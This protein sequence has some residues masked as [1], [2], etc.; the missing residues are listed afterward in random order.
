MEQIRKHNN[1]RPQE[2]SE[3]AKQRLVQ[4]IVRNLLDIQI[5]RL[6]R[7]EPTWGYRL[8]KQAEAKFGIK[9]RHGALYPSLN[10]LEQEGFLTSHGQKQRGRTR[11]VYTITEKGKR[12]VDTYHKILKDQI[13]G[14]DLK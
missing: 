8:K 4:R 3:T 12:Y 14:E 5:L 9:L 13:E 2:L 10:A 1:P 7:I 6:I 11:K